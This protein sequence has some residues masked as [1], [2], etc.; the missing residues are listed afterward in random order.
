MKKIIPAIFLL[1]M[2]GFLVSAANC[3]PSLPKTYLGNV[4]SGSSALIGNFEI[5]AMMSDDNVG[6]GNITKREKKNNVSPCPTLSG[7][8]VL[9]IITSFRT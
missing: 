6:I 8:A 7:D 3:P 5:R 4:S 1:L 2:F 9:S